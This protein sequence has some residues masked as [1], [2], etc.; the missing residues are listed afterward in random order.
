MHNLSV[1]RG[2]VGFN[3]PGLGVWGLGRR[4]NLRY[5]LS[6]VILMATTIVKVTAIGNSAGIL[7]PKEV[8]AKL[9]VAKGD[10]LY[11]IDTPDGIQLTPYDQDFAEEMEV[12]R[13]IMKENRDVLRRLAE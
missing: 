2:G 5:N 1:D 6:E 13:Q 10:S 12:A 7:L 8:L 11:L 4:Y 9:K 3:A